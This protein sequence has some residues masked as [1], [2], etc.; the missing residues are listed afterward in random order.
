[1]TESSDKG[2]SRRN[3]LKMAGIA[4]VAVQ[5]GGLYVAGK[6]AGASSESYTGWE[7]F[8]PGAQSWIFEMEG[9]EGWWRKCH[10]L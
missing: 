10:T 9:N 6:R 5:A 2:I 7:S 1:M 4:G 3:L 8:N